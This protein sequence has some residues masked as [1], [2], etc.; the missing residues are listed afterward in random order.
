VLRTDP[1]PE[2]ISLGFCSHQ[3]S[4]RPSASIPLIFLLAPFHF[5][6]LGVNTLMRRSAASGVSEAESFIEF[7][8]EV[9]VEPVRIKRAQRSAIEIDGLS[10]ILIFL[11]PHLPEDTSEQI[12]EE[13]L[14]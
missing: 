10:W 8:S 12:E 11:P 2:R 6:C 14:N 1:T 5:V 3:I 4:G 9:V 13:F 7:L